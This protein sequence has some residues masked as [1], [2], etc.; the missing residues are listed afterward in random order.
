MRC[1]RWEL[2]GPRP[3]KSQWRICQVR[4]QLDCKMSRMSFGE[5]VCLDDFCRATPYCT[6]I[7]DEARKPGLA[8]GSAHAALCF[9][10]PSHGRPLWPFPVFIEA[11]TMQVGWITTLGAGG[12]SAVKESNTSVGAS[13]FRTLNCVVHH[14][15]KCS[16]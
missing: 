7:V 8:H 4:H 10:R 13:H 14:G 12:W 11:R 3:S 2:V 1:M 16:P 15:R 6:I 9:P 5:V